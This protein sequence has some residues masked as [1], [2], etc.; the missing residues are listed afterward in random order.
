MGER[1]DD[2]ALD[3]DE[4]R[5]G[6]RR[7]RPGDHVPLLAQQPDR[8]GRDRGDGRRGVLERGARACVVVDEAY[9]Q[10]APWSALEL[11]D[12]DAPLVVTRTFSKTWSMAAARL[13][14]LRRPGVGGRRARE[15]RAAVPPRRGQAGRR[16]GSRSTS[17]SEMEARVADARRGAGPAGRP[18]SATCRVDVWPSG[19]NFVLFRPADRR[20]RRRVAGAAR[21]LGARPQLRVV[22]PP[23]RLPAGHHRHPR[24]GRRLPRRPR[25]RSS[26]DEPHEPH[27]HAPAHHQGDR[28]ST[29]DA[30]PRRAHGRGRASHRPAVLRPHARP[31][32][33]PRRLRPHRRGR[34]ATSQVDGHHTVEDV[35]ILLGEAFA[36]GAR[37]QGRRAPLRVSGLFPLD[38]ALVEVAL[39]LSGRPFV[40]YD[41]PV[42]RGAAARRPAVR[43]GDGRALLAVVRHRRP[44]SPCT[45]TSAAG[46]NTHHVVEATFK[47]VARCLR[48]AVRV[49]G[50]RR[51]VDQGRAVSAANGR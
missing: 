33:P 8:P 27:R 39:D 32:R 4:V 17:S 5:P 15:G 40:V 12:E 28:R 49:E 48:D 36:R 23:R 37:R 25:R 46:S 13:G 16:A 34:R 26:H 51:A 22:A 6:P 11:V 41:V 38:E 3:L 31:A 2:F 45:C 20:R 43:P 47:G 19:A 10:F 24:R 35:G 14:Y 1:T 42:R 44:A 7:R 50:T 29:I 21:P 30:R 18:R 9:G